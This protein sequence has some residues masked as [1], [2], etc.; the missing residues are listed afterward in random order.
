MTTVAIQRTDGGVSLMTIN[1][2]ELQDEIDLFFAVQIEVDKWAESWGSLPVAW[3]IVTDAPNNREYREAWVLNNGRVVADMPKARAVHRAK[4][5]EVRNKRLDNL[6]K[7]T[8]KAIDDDDTPTRQQ[9]K[10]QKQRLRDAPADAR[11][12]AAQSIAELRALTLEVLITDPPAR[13]SRAG[14]T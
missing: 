11:I 4:I 9:I 1:D 13:P 10:A 7:D 6:D 12:D 5:R 3:A 2:A 14:R 8:I